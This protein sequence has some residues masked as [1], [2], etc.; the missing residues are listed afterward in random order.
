MAAKDANDTRRGTRRVTDLGERRL[1]ARKAGEKPKCGSPLASARKKGHPNY[2]KTCRQPAGAGTDHPGYGTCSRHAGGMPAAKVSAARERAAETVDTLR[3]ELMFYGHKVEI[4]YEDA[5]LEEL[6]RSVAVVRW[7][8]GK[9]S[10]WGA[11]NASFWDHNETKMPSLLQVHRGTYTVTISD[12]EYAAWLRQYGFERK[13][14]AAVA[15]DGIRSGIAKAVIQIYQQQADMMN[16]IIRRTL[17]ALGLDPNDDRL[18]TVLPVVIREV[19]AE[20]KAS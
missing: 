8:E 14:L 13:H 1:A 11:D 18:P 19:V 4:G 20:F 9:L 2:G 17:E 3:R 6:Q 12:T 5:H 10:A 16:R 15:S 7:I